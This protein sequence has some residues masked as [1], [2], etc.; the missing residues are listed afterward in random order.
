MKKHTK[1]DNDFGSVSGNAN[2]VSI[3]NN[4]MVSDQWE[5]VKNDIVFLLQ[6][7][8]ITIVPPVGPPVVVPVG[9]AVK[10]HGV[11]LDARFQRKDVFFQDGDTTI[12]PNGTMVYEDGSQAEAAVFWGAL[13]PRYYTTVI[14]HY[15][16]NVKHSNQ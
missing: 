12:F 3:Q 9:R 2:D 13:D 1:N 14:K 7:T 5:V 16:L 8:V 15:I 4:Y 10:D 6:S 11:V